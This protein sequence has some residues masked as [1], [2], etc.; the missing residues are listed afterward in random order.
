MDESTASVT[1]LSTL[2]V[3][4]HN[5]SRLRQDLGPMTT[6]ELGEP[7]AVLSS[8]DETWHLRC[9]SHGPVYAQR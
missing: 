8:I 9:A 1:L 4:P 5:V 7:H 2:E 6:L 3:P